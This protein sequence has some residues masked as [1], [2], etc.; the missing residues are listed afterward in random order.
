MA[1]I[2]INHQYS[3]GQLMILRISLVFCL[4]SL[5]ISARAQSDLTATA[6]GYNLDEVNKG[7]YLLASVVVENVGSSLSKQAKASFHLFQ[8][9]ELSHENQVGF[10]S[11][12][13]LQPFEKDTLIFILNVTDN[14]EQGAYGVGV[15]LD[16][17]NNEVETNEGNN[18]FSGTGPSS[19]HL[20]VLNQTEENL[21]SAYPILFIHGLGSDDKTWNTTSDALSNQYGYINGGTLHYCLNPDGDVTTSDAG[22][23]FSK[24]DFLN[25]ISE[26]DFYTVNF[27]LSQG[28]IP[29]PPMML[30][31]LSNQSAIVK[32]GWA[33][34]DAIGQIL[35]VTGA[36]RIVL[37]GHS[38]GGLAAREYI[39]DTMKWQPS[40]YHHVVKLHTIDTPHGGSNN[41]SFIVNLSE[42]DSN[43]EA[44]RDLKFNEG[45]TVGPYLNNGSEFQVTGSYNSDVNCNGV[46]DFTTGLNDR[47]FPS[48]L[49]YS[50]SIATGYDWFLYDVVE[51]WSADLERYID[52]VPEAQ[53]PPIPKFY[54]DA[55][56]SGIQENL[57]FLLA[58]MDQPLDQPYALQMDR[59]YSEFVTQQGEDFITSEDYDTYL[60][61]VEKSGTLD[62]SIFN[63]TSPN[64]LIALF[65]ANIDLIETTQPDGEDYK[66]LSVDVTEGTYLVT[67]VSE[68]E[69]FFSEQKI[70]LS[71][72]YIAA[73]HT[74]FEPIFADF[75]STIQ[76]SCSP[77][78]VQYEDASSGNYDTYEWQF[79]GGV[80]ATS[81][82]QNPFVEYETEGV[83]TTTLII[84]NEFQSD[85]LTYDSYVE[86]KDVPVSDFVSSILNDGEIQVSANDVDAN[87][88][89]EW[90]FGDQS[91]ASGSGASHI[92]EE[93]GTYT[94]VLTVTNECGSSTTSEQVLVQP[95]DKP[96]MAFIN[97][98]DAVGCVP[99]EVQYSAQVSEGN[100]NTFFWQFEGGTPAESSQQ[101]PSV[102]YQTGGR[103]DVYMIASNDSYSTEELLSA[104]VLAI[105]VPE[106]EFE[107]KY[108]GDAEVEFRIK[109]PVSGIV[110][111][112]DF[113]DGN[114]SVG[115][116]V[117]QSYMT[118]GLYSVSVTS[119]NN[120]GSNQS[121]EDVLIDNSTSTEDLSEEMSVFPN[122]SSGAFMIQ[123]D[124]QDFSF[125]ELC[126]S[127][128]RKVDCM[129]SVD[130]PNSIKVNCSN[131]PSGVYFLKVGRD[132]LVLSRKLIILG[133]R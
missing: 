57:Q 29:N 27:D 40:G 77:A 91:S 61:E 132:D 51:E 111:H 47:I 81:I 115:P 113:G 25:N 41:W 79:E 82:E 123:Q 133:N 120:C 34:Q 5:C 4:L 102:M 50:C 130:S 26:G 37:V 109:K 107:W 95:F 16:R 56:H 108:L 66:L 90:D 64:S 104:Y 23:Y 98:E 89:Y 65:D 131:L 126:D 87:Y 116:V 99:F 19:T 124:G 62:V 110:Y 67:V 88:T 69:V 17:Y 24:Y 118:N 86:V 12:H 94:V 119:E 54:V 92:Y 53:K 20:Q 32:Q 42:N 70:Q 101:N 11:I 97:S 33:L 44:I 2:A 14:M 106:T 18:R 48:D 73:Q 96:I 112:W 45:L 21:K 30:D 46:I 39:Q 58:G 72:Y 6:F 13:P 85:T 8:G 36:D 31:V 71:P 3:L 60:I 83:Y 114:T 74:P 121:Q 59:L 52:V 117:T 63:Q 128:G 28:G 127:R 129:S 49:A 78:V 1:D 43:S 103:Y 122:P 15:W 76:F 105:D 80:P 10:V 100:P 55:W 35:D 38:M 93:A 9:N 84:S 68:P 22:T 7:G 125:V 75:I